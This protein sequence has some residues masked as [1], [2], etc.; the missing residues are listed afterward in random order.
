MLGDLTRE[1]PTETGSFPPMLPEELV[2]VLPWLLPL[3]VVPEPA[4]GVVVPGDAADDV[5]PPLTPPSG[6]PLTLA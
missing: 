5:T 2:V 3:L 6:T 1:W 4:A